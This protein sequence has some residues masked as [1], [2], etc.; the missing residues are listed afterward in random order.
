MALNAAFAT[1][2]DGPLLGSSLPEYGGQP[3][4]VRC[5]VL[6]SANDGVEP[7]ISVSK[8]A[9]DTVIFEVVFF[10]M[11]SFNIGVFAVFVVFSLRML[12]PDYC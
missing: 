4:E 12:P 2:I 9:N 1:S 7:S 10:M 11:I 5:T 3:N 8:K 6:L